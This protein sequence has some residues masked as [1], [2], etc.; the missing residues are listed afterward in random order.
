MFIA[1]AFLLFQSRNIRFF[2]L[3]VIASSQNAISEKREGLTEAIII[4]PTYRHKPFTTKQKLI[5][6]LILGETYF[7]SKFVF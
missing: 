6:C 7:E 3:S 1:K 2:N 5:M 4:F